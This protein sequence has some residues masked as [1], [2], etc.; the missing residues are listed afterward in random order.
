MASRVTVRVL[1]VA[2]V[3]CHG[4]AKIVPELGMVRLLVIC[5]TSNPLFCN[6]FGRY[7]SVANLSLV[8]D[9]T[10][11][12]SGTGV[13]PFSILLI[14]EAKSVHNAALFL[15]SIIVPATCAAAVV[16]SCPRATVRV[17]TE[18]PL[19]IITSYSQEQ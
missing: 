16:P 17:S 15:C 19:Q 10:G 1:L 18:R 9:P 8:I 12:F 2:T 7:T 14:D 5:Q 6:K 11:A 13:V 4:S 3:P